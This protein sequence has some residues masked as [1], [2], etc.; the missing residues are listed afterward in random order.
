MVIFQEF[1][2]Q[3]KQ[4]KSLV[5]WIDFTFWGSGKIDYKFQL[6]FLLYTQ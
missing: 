3:I 6:H 5:P 1:S 2:Y 4:M